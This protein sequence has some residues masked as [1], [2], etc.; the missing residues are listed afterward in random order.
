MKRS[1]S[2]AKRHCNLEF[3]PKLSFWL[4]YCTKVDQKIDLLKVISIFG[5]ISQRSALE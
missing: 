2:G 1:E 3:N 4:L 5:L